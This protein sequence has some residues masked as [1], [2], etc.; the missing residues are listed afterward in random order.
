MASAVA[1]FGRMSRI[2]LGVPLW[3][4]V[5]VAD[6]ILTVPVRS[7]KLGLV[8]IPSV[9]V[10]LPNLLPGSTTEIHE[11]LEVTFQL[12]VESAETATIT[13]SEL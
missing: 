9:T 13:M 5:K 11:S 3:R 2:G 10:E 6:P 12:V 4:I 7:R 8:P 1:T